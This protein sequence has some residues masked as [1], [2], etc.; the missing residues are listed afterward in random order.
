M[1]TKP[2]FETNA[3]ATLN[4]VAKTFAERGQQYGDGWRDNQWLAMRAAAHE[5][6]IHLSLNECRALAAGAMVDIKYQRLQG[7]YKEDSVIDGIAYSA[8]FAKEMQNLC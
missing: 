7:G 3:E 1:K 8:Y 5:M 2:L 6:G 4:Q